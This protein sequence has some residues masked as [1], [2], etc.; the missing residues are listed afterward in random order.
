MPGHRKTGSFGPE[1]ETPFCVSMSNI[2]IFLNITEMRKMTSARA[3]ALK[4]LRPEPKRG[5]RNRAP[6]WMPGCHAAREGGA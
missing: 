3:P 5:V 2:F 6:G 4:D 1:V